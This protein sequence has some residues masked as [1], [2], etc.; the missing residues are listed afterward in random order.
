MP[1]INFTEH[2]DKVMLVDDE[3]EVTLLI[4]DVMREQGY[5]VETAAS[6]IDALQKMETYWP[7]II[8][9]D[10]RMPGMDGF[11]FC[12][13]VRE[14]PQFQDIPF[15][16]LSAVDDKEFV[17]TGRVAGADEY[18]V[19]PYDIIDVLLAVQTKLERMRSLKGK[20]TDENVNIKKSFSLESLA[21]IDPLTNFRGSIFNELERCPLEDI[22]SAIQKNQNLS[23]IDKIFQNI[24]LYVELRSSS[25]HSEQSDIGK[26]GYTVNLKE[27]FDT[28]IN[29]I[30]DELKKKEINLKKD[31][32]ADTCVI[33]MQEHHFRHLC[34]VIFDY[35]MNHIMTGSTL[36]MTVREGDKKLLLAVEATQFQP[37]DEK[38][39][40]GLMISQALVEY[41]GG[42]FSHVRTE[43]SGIEL[44]LSI[45]LQS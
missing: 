29:P 37:A 25:R 30:Q 2:K 22:H 33:A 26:K 42:A 5:L 43:S 38:N 20:F 45:P 21:P 9:S 35:V 24:L 41:Y 8:V 17:R 36:N 32:Q 7:D 28:L 13:H 1:Q 4:A 40:T 27:Y 6:G 16:F 12:Q 19:K 31:F 18:L 44:L 14:K 11:E 39:N 15:I 10:V 34:A 23:V 3:I